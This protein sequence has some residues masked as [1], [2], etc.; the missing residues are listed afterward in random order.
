MSQI[1][2]V[3]IDKVDSF[4]NFSKQQVATANYLINFSLMIALWFHGIAC[5]WMYI[6]YINDGSWIVSNST[7]SRDGDPIPWLELSLGT[8]YIKALYWTVTTLTTVGYGDIVG[9]TIY[10]YLFTMFAEFIGIGIFSLIMGSTQ[11]ILMND[12]N[13]SDY[14]GS[15]LEAV[16]VW[17]VRLDNSRLT[18]SLPAV[19]YDKIKMYIEESLYYNN[20][21]L[22]E[23]ADFFFQLKPSIRYKLVMELYSKFKRLNLALF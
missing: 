5:L 4:S 12:G 11:S 14:M 23:Q 1:I 3:I 19:L 22:I 20:D 7:P 21:L 8:I 2:G 16:E 13:I 18:D 10:E 9:Y 6:G 17:L 15:K